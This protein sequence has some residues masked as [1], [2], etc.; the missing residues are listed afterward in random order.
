[1]NRKKKS[2]LLVI[3]LQNDFCTGGPIEIPHFLS[4]IPVINRIRNRFDVVVFSKDWHPVDHMSFVDNGGRWPPHCIQSTNGA[5]IHPAV[6]ITDKDYII[7][8]GTDSNYDAYSAFYN[9]KEIG[10]KSALHRIL[11]ENDVNNLYVC[12]I[13]AEYC[14]YSTLLDA[15]RNKHANYKCYL[16]K[17]ATVGLDDDK[18]QRCYMRLQKLGVRIVR[19]DDIQ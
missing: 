4:I 7:H 10:S 19:A 16:V 5:N 14:V 8:K 17:D 15:I 9:S 6:D 11:D 18:I 13:G 2:A 12:G 1:M 3:D